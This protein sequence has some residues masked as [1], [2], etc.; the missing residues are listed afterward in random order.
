MTLH[1]T[2]TDSA[3]FES[4]K[5]QIAVFHVQIAR[6]YDSVCMTC[7]MATWIPATEDWI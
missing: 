7:G 4:S 5:R 6:I 1:I 3:H 2:N